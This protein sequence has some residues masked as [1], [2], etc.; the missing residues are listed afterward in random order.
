MCVCV[1]LYFLANG[2]NS[3]AFGIQLHKITLK[4]RECIVH[5]VYFILKKSPKALFK[6]SFFYSDIHIYRALMVCGGHFRETLK[7]VLLSQ[8]SDQRVFISCLCSCTLEM[9]CQVF[10]EVSNDLLP[11]LLSVCCVLFSHIIDMW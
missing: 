8:R 11:A 5:W 7:T 1:W 10:Y 2:A 3:V 9:V 6:I 4:K